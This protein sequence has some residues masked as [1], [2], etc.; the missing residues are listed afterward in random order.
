MQF[1]LIK[2]FYHFDFLEL[3][4]VSLLAKKKISQGSINW[5][6]NTHSNQISQKPKFPGAD[7]SVE[8]GDWQFLPTTKPQIT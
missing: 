4:I 6:H 7:V 8:T 3:Q 2:S 5:Q 1:F